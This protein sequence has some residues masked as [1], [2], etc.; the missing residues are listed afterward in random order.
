[1]WCLFANFIGSCKNVPFYDYIENYNVDNFK[2][3]KCVVDNFPSIS[4]Y[5][6]KLS[7]MN[8][9]YD[10]FQ[11]FKTTLWWDVVGFLIFVV[12]ETSFWFYKKK[13]GWFKLLESIKKIYTQMKHL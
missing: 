11:N 8:K 7:S 10:K 2:D 4:M 3:L 9:F 13:E 5:K 6:N 12:W 1:M